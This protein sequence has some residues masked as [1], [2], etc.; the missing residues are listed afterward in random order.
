MTVAV[1]L[2]AESAVLSKTAENPP[3][4]SNVWTG[5]A[6]LA[7]ACAAI[8]ALRNW[9][10]PGWLK[11]L[12][13]LGAAALAMVL[14]DIGL[15]R[16]DRDPA[17]LSRTPLRSIDIVRIWQKLVG[18]WLTIGTIAVGYAML[19][20]YAHDLYAPFF[21][22]ALWCLPFVA[23]ASP[24]YIAFVDRRQRD[25][26]DA[27]VQVALL[28]AGQRPHDWAG[29]KLHALGWLVKGFFLPLMFAFAHDG[30]T[31]LWARDSLSSLTSFQQIFAFTIDLFY[32][33]DVLIAAVAYTLTVQLLG[34]SIR[35]VEPTLA[36]W[37]VCLVCYPPFVHSTLNAYLNYNQDELYWGAVFDVH[38]MLYVLWGMIILTLVAIYMAAT[39]AFG[40]RFSNLTHRGIITSG[41]YRWSKH[42]AYI[43]KNL[44]WWMV[45][46]PF[47]A[48]AG[49]AIAI[50]S[51]VLLLGVN[52][53]YFL[54]AK[55][56][57]RHL[58]VDPVYRDYEA[59]I[60]AHGLFARL[61]RALR[62]PDPP[63][64][65]YALD[66]LAVLKVWATD[67]GQAV[68]TPPEHGMTQTRTTFRFWL[69]I[70][71]ASVIFLYICHLF[72]A[73]LLIDGVRWFWLD[74]DQMISMRYARNL[75]TGYG[76]VWNPGELVEGYTNFGWVMIMAAI[77]LLPL[78]DQLMP[79]AMKFVSAAFCLTAVFIAAR[80]VQRLEPRGLAYTLPAVLILI[81]SCTDVMFWAVSGFET[82]LVTALH[83]AVVYF[84]I[85]GCRLDA[86]LLV[87]LALIPIIRSD[88]L[89]IWLGDAILVFWLAQNRRQAAA[90]LLASLA[91]FVAHLVFR[92]AYYGELMPNTYYLKVV[93]LDD[94]WSRGF[95][96]VRGF[97]ERYS[98]VLILAIATAA[99]LWR[100]DVRTRSFVTSLVPPML[101][102]TYVGGDAF[103]PYR[104]FAHVMPELFVWAAIGAVC[105]VKTPLARAAWISVPIVVIALPRLANPFTS[106][107]PVG[108]NGRPYDSVI[109][110]AQLLK[111]AAPNATVAVIP[112]GIVPYFTHLKAVDLLGKTD[113]HIAR[114]PPREG[115]LVGHGKIDP[116]YSFAKEP[117]Y[118]V[119]VR[120]KNF[121]DAIGPLPPEG[122]TDYVVSLL[123]SPQFQKSWKSN[124]V[125]DP[126]LVEH[127]AMYVGSGSPEMA[128]L[129]SWKGVVIAP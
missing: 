98:V 54:R 86:K 10:E 48:G 34:T 61:F 51:C 113:A 71:F 21:S 35:S 56:E 72:T 129:P 2:S 99:S 53:I 102:A 89:H 91:P 85:S 107:V 24:F 1:R 44:S 47:V 57:E 50:Q 32:L 83:L 60:R 70:A 43:A 41:P 76:L 52:F 18:L 122:T 49:W 29:L 69:A 38:P 127:S 75:A 117:D 4:A 112:A 78:P 55:T 103:N 109:V 59:Y 108:D 45:S 36:G 84:A 62:R 118:V 26:N 27:Y 81:L 31:Q 100:S 101:Y 77:H 87:P 20:E 63:G 111:N 19:S 93:G 126:Y 12:A 74:D 23:V 96:Y 40:L 64:T 11:T 3:S 120:S 119:S 79:V 66:P 125:P 30:L 128:K 65:P 22:A 110:A 42:P 25:P 39:V 73:S 80:L 5:I 124:A 33:F 92:F 17:G 105:L 104:L 121:V 97:C 28:F 94:R 116:A 88:G 58:R 123:A 37:A 67:A 106:I 16:S 9:E 82:I 95:E 7:A 46:V 90:F 13:V 6:G 115:A 15:N 68:A 8:Y 14:V 114:L